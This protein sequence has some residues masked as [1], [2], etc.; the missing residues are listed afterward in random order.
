MKS[1]KSPY[2]R[3]AN[4]GINILSIEVN[5]DSGE[6]FIVFEYSWKDPKQD[7]KLHWSKSIESHYN[8]NTLCGNILQ[9]VE[10][11]RQEL[12]ANED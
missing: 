8:L 5:H 10:L 11:A 2:A 6:K 4:A 3:L 9:K 12:E 7:D 1:Y